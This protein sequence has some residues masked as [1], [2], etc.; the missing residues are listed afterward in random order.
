MGPNSTFL[1]GSPL[2]IE[3]MED[4]NIK[5]EY[6]WKLHQGLNSPWHASDPPCR[7]CSLGPGA[8]RSSIVQESRVATGSRVQASAHRAG[9]TALPRYALTFTVMGLGGLGNPGLAEGKS[10]CTNEP[11]KAPTL[12]HGGHCH[13]GR[14]RMGRGLWGRVVA[15]KQ[16]SYT[17]YH[18]SYQ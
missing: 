5:I 10:L 16:P 11:C 13:Q 17:I 14:A 2:R 8:S 9:C 15:R 3:Q 4:L 1:F 12:L 6:D 18:F 7:L